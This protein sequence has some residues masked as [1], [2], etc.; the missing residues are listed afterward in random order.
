QLSASCSPKRRLWIW[1]DDLEHLTFVYDPTIGLRR[2][3]RDVMYIRPLN[4]HFHTIQIILDT[5][6]LNGMNPGDNV[7]SRC[8]NINADNHTTGFQPR[9][10]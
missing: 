9:A 5:R 6:L 2:E 4:R 7:H 1:F 3:L 10:I 8:F